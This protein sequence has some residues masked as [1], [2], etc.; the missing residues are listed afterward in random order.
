MCVCVCVCVRVCVL[1][2]CGP[3]VPWEVLACLT[4]LSEI[5][6]CLGLPLACVVYV[7]CV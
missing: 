4:M 6:R 7:Y 2:V 5:C 1:Q 3:C